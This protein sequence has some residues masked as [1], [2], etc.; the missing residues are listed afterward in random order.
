MDYKQYPEQWKQYNERNAKYNIAHGL[1]DADL[2]VLFTQVEKLPSGST[3]VEVGISEG[4]AFLAVAL[5][6]PDIKCYGIEIEPNIRNGQKAIEDLNIKNVELLLGKG[7]EEVCKTWDKEIDLI[8]IDAHHYFPNVFWDYV[9]WLPHVKSG[10]KMLFHDYEQSH[11]PDQVFDVGKA[12]QIFRGHPKY[13]IWIPSEDDRISSSI[14]VIT[15][16]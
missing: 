9:G 6:R 13:D 1:Y 8:F 2:N 4:S 3:Y 7:S 15:K 10:G 14:P 12:F 11:R 5:F 16:I